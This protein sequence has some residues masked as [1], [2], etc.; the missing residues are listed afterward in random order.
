MVKIT[1]VSSFYWR[2][3]SRTEEPSGGRE[4]GM[5]RSNRP[6]ATLQQP[7]TVWTDPTGQKPLC[8]NLWH[9]N[10]APD[11]QLLT[12]DLLICFIIIIIIKNHHHIYLYTGKPV[13]LFC[14]VWMSFWPHLGSNHLF[15]IH[16][17]S[18]FDLKVTK[19]LR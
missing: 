18:R 7:M 14:T 2:Y 11:R 19:H 16:C 3:G 6:K 1:K 9:I 10:A 4:K 15:A 8:S 5:D 17:R 12:G 13:W